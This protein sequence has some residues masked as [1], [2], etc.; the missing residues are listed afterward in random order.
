MMPKLNI[1]VNIQFFT[2]WDYIHT[3]IHSYTSYS[4]LHKCQQNP[5]FK[6]SSREGIWKNNRTVT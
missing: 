5:G 2:H 3:Y 4:S 6:M 1:R